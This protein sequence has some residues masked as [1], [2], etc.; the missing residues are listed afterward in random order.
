MAFACT[1]DSAVTNVGLTQGSVVEAADVATLK[2]GVEELKTYLNG[3]GGYSAGATA[4]I[5]GHTGII[6]DEFI[7][8][9]RTL[10]GQLDGQT[11]CTCNYVCS[12]DHYC[13]CNTEYTVCSC[14]AQTVCSPNCG[15]NGDYVVA[16]SSNTGCSGN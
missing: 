8:S 14:E 9:M 16:C 15:C 10:L 13:S 2:N 7:N 12:N 6:S 3:S 5:S 4:V 1:Y 11:C